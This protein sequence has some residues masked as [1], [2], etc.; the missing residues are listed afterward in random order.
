MPTPVGKCSNLKCNEPF[1]EKLTK[2]AFAELEKQLGV[3]TSDTPIALCQLCYNALYCQLHPSKPVVLVELD[4]KRI[5]LF[6]AT[7][8]SSVV[9]KHLTATTGIEDLLPRKPEELA[10]LG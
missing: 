9:S 3:S 4:P 5:K 6:V 8:H 10:S 2:H 1:T 7:A